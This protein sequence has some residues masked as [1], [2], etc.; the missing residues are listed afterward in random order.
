MAR[1][2]YYDIVGINGNAYCIMG[3]VSTAMAQEC[4]AMGWD[5]A[6]LKKEKDAYLNDAMSGDYNHLVA[7]SADMVDRINKAI[8]GGS[9]N[10]D[11]G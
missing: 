5:A 11:K 7:V 3:Y 10:D 1:K 6:A 4:E 8:S 2:K 9:E